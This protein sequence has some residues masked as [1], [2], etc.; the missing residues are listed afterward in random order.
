MGIAKRL[1]KN[2]AFLFLNKGAIFFI[3]VTGIIISTS[4]L[5]I[6]LSSQ[7]RFLK[8]N[9]KLDVNRRIFA[10][11]KEVE[12][13][14][15]IVAAFK[16]FYE[17][18]E[19]VERDAFSKFSHE[20]IK[21]RKYVETLLWVPRVPKNWRKVFEESALK[22]GVKE[23]SFSSFDQDNI[24][25]VSPEKEYYYPAYFVEPQE[26]HSEMLGFDLNQVDEL[27]RMLERARETGQMSTVSWTYPIEKENFSNFRIVVANPIY[28]D[29]GK[30]IETEN[31]FLGFVVVILKGDLFFDDALNM[32]SP[33]GMHIF[34]SEVPTTDTEKIKYY[35]YDD[36]KKL[37]H[38]DADSAEFKYFSDLKIQDQIWLADKPWQVFFYA[39]SEYSFSRYLWMPWAIFAVG[40]IMTYLLCAFIYSVLSSKKLLQKLNDALKEEADERKKIGRLIGLSEVR[41]R[42][43]MD[44][45]PHMIYAKDNEGRFLIVNRFTA[46]VYGKTVDELVGVK[47]KDVHLQKE[48]VEKYDA[49]DAYVLLNQQAVIIDEEPFENVDGKAQ[50]L[51]TTKMPFFWDEEKG[52]VVLAISIDMTDAKKTEEL[53]ASEERFRG[54]VEKSHDAIFLIDSTG[55]FSDVNQKAVEI[56]GYDRNE[57]LQKKLFDID[58]GQSES[59]FKQLWK[60]LEKGA[61]VTKESFCRR[62]D[63]HFFPVEMK[64]SLITIRD[65]EYILLNLRDISKL[66][67]MNQK[68]KET[69]AFLDSIIENIPNM[70]FIKDAKKLKFIRLNKAGENLLGF[71]EKDLIGKDDYDFFPKEEADFFVEKDRQVLSEGK[72][73]NIPDEKVHT[74]NGPRYLHTKKMPI[75]NELGEVSYLLGISEDITEQKMARLDLEQLHIAMENALDGI[76]KLGDDGK[77]LSANKSL[78]HLLVFSDFAKGGKTWRDFIHLQDQSHMKTLLERASEK[79][80]AEGEVRAIKSNGVIFHIQIVIIRNDN[81]FDSECHY[82]CFIK[83]ISERKYHQAIEHK[84][85]LIS[86]VSHE[87]RTP[88]H[89]IRE[90]VSVMLDGLTGEI[91]EQQKR[92]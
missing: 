23:F 26:K 41:L 4:L 7:Q 27:A 87:L 58:F 67:N 57:L 2:L 70:I 21:G 22:N 20:L 1:N 91:S 40:I 16:A 30:E 61:C 47:Q 29:Q 35:H 48:Q 88:I 3:V 82:Y 71:L 53:R 50:I 44:M 60:D 39:T 69:N 31:E 72:L 86:M 33:K 37:G 62:K 46:D 73:L 90:G 81:P 68:L 34:F 19:R 5:S 15:S 13:T 42:Q 18:S 36:K 28:R 52:D 6:L 65:Q 80:K 54:L 45:V 63:K 9:F 89:S 8:T 38:Y 59:K 55:F 17:G 75:Y 77:V 32:F 76:A 25:R 49:D 12:N 11:Q 92:S 79:Q 10:L 85:E 78:T 43:I 83:D 56:L 74:K 66:K 84:S 51:R 64:A 24:L 14:K